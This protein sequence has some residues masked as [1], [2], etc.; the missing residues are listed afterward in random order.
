MRQFP[1]MIGYEGTKGPCPSWIPWD[2]I[3]PYEGQARQNHQQSLEELAGRGG[4]SPVEAFYVM[5]GRRWH[6]EQFSDEIRKE[7]CAFLDKVV[8]DR[9]ELQTRL[10]AAF[11]Q[12]DE[13]R[14]ER[15]GYQ[16]GYTDAEALRHEL[17]LQLSGLQKEV[18]EFFA[19]R[20]EGTA[21]EESRAAA[22]LRDL[23][24]KPK[25]AEIDHA[26]GACDEKTC[27]HCAAF[28]K[29]EDA[30]NRKEGS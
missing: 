5:T 17:E 21:D 4:L 9:G 28:R 24:E 10:D 27:E 20:D 6:R 13:M 23:V 22:K 2:A 29:Q 15:D 26:R 30:E 14:K 25:S 12:L 19:A 3:A 16:A 7:A 11:L 8:R 1:I 18:V